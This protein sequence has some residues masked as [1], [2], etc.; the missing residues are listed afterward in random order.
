M[1]TQEII[2]KV[3]EGQTWT[4]LGSIDLRHK[5]AMRDLVRM[6]FIDDYERIR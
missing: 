1:V 6:R 5:I 3:P 2:L 4:I